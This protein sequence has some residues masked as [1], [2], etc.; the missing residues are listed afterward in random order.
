MC[1]LVSRV[2]V[3][4]DENVTHHFGFSRFSDVVKMRPEKQ[5]HVVKSQLEILQ[6]FKLDVQN[7]LGQINCIIENVVLW[8]EEKDDTQNFFQINQ[9]LM[10]ET[11]NCIQKC[12]LIADSNQHMTLASSDK[13]RAGQST[14][15]NFKDSD[16][17]Q[18]LISK[19]E[20]MEQSFSSLQGACK[21]N[22]VQCSVLSE[23]T[24]T[25]SKKL[26]NLREK[27][28]SQEKRREDGGEIDA[29]FDEIVRELQAASDFMS[30]LRFQTQ[31]LSTKVD[32]LE[33]SATKSV[34]PL[35]TEMA[36]ISEVQKMCEASMEQLVATQANK[37]EELQ[38][39][40]SE[41][42]IKVNDASSEIEIVSQQLT[43]LA[44]KQKSI[45]LSAQV[46]S[47]HPMFDLQMNET[48]QCFTHIIYNTKSAY[49]PSTGVFT[50]QCDGL[51][52]CCV[53]MESANETDI[54]VDICVK[55]GSGKEVSRGTLHSK[56]SAA[57][58]SL[59]VPVKLR[60]DEWL[61]LKSK[62]SYSKIKLS[63]YSF[64]V[65]ILVNE[66]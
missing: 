51:Y 47:A 11:S 26:K 4:Y 57:H 41:Q 50:A 1:V 61:Y 29:K 14:A 3:N 22:E 28:Q 35:K 53:F 65:C 40:I 6:E 64:F 15:T 16:E 54:V 62:R 60:A 30:Q 37:L 48:L 42:D 55:D 17:Y 44:S 36:K 43:Q 7:L 21:N 45:F 18:K 58:G 49:D 52:L 12:L 24:A 25:H 27:V 46:P 56:T 10:T 8:I 33:G 23:L 59:V 32:E 5:L 34:D 66:D 38:I 39:L 13:D 63:A 9:Y 19:F 2:Y 31:S 20:E